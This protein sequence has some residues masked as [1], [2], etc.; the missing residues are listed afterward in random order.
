M[1]HFVFLEFLDPRVTEVLE[2]L[3]SALQPW[4]RSRSPMHVT[5]RGPYQ[6]LPEN[7]L[8]LQLSDGIRG[9]GVRII[10]SGYFS[11]GKGEFAVFLRAESAVFRELW[12]KPDFPVK[13]DDIE[14]HVTVFESNDR[15]SAQLVYNFLRAARIS[16]LTYSVQ[17]SVYSTGQQDLFGTKKVGV[18]PPNSDWRRDIVAIDDDT[19]PAARELGQRLLARREAA[20]PKPSGDA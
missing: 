19:L 4:K 9:Q 2:E 6:S 20:K 5:V 12:W 17:L 7:N 14:P 8:L 1:A 15:T 11:Y 16:I 10:G 18:R 13:P 3:R